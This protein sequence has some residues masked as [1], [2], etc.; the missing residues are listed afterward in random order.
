[1]NM[2]WVYGLPNW[3]FCI[4]TVAAFV[5]VGLVGLF[6]SRGWVRRLHKIDHS[7]NDVVGFYLAAVTVFYGITLGLLAIGTWTTYSDVQGRIDHEATALGGLYRDVSAYPDPARTI[8]QD[9]LRRYARAVIDVGW[10]M[11]QRGII[12]NNATTILSD[13]QSHFMSFEPTNE[14]E[15]ILAAEAYRTF[16]ELTE[17]RRAR[18][19]SVTAE[20]PG[21]LWTLVMVGAL[22]C[23]GLTWF[24]H[25]ASLRM[26][27]WMTILFSGLLG[28]MIYLVAVLDNPYRGKVSV[29]PEPLE[30][31]YEQVM[32]PA[33]K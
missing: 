23:I 27:V 21:P 31:V 13:F 4:L 17:R 18:L 11:Q 25:M 1:M 29:S 26:H 9:D 15:K 6:L 16:N 19:N 2:Y 32:T 14:R 8:M 12:P 28:L 5:A 22:I 3:I 7:H 30:R 33:G 10:P 24:F 20:M